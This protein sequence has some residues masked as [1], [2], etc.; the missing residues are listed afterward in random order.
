MSGRG[1][2]PPKCFYCG[3]RPDWTIHL[4]GERRQTCDAHRAMAMAESRTPRIQPH[5]DGTAR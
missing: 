4:G 1:D 2:T 5:V 3:R